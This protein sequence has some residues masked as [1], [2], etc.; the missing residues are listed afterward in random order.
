MQRFRIHRRLSHRSIDTLILRYSEVYLN[1]KNSGKL[2]K[3]RGKV[4]LVSLEDGR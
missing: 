1:A 4:S 2:S 3:R